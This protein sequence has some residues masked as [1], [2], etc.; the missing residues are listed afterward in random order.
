VRDK[1]RAKSLALRN[2]QRTVDACIRDGY[3]TLDD[4]GIFHLTERAR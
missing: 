2:I 3:V 1:G 4:E